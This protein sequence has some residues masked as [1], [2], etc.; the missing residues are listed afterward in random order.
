MFLVA[1]QPM[2]QHFGITGKKILHVKRSKEGGVENYRG[3]IVEYTH[4]I[5]QTT[6][7]DA[8]LASHAGIYHRQQR[9]GDIDILDAAL[10]GRCSKAPQV[11][12]HAS[13]QV[14]H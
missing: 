2:L 7:V 14:N 5:L 1:D 6:K 13:A 8:R 12:Y 9:R 4:L 11:G 3:G 10:E